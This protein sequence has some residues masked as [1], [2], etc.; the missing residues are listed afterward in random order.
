MK[1]LFL[2]TAN[3]CR[4]ILSEAVFNHL[5]PP[6]LR[7]FSAGSHARGEVLPRT[8]ATLRAAGIAVDGLTSK[9]IEAQ[10]DLNPDIVI[11]VCDQAAGDA[12]P[13]FLGKAIKV[14]W[15]LEDPSRLNGSEAEIIDAFDAALATIIRRTN[16]FLNLRADQLSTEQLQAELI[17]IGNL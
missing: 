9:A 12:C 7:A 6:G 14:H 1:V 13:L 10:A 4:S 3:S 15:G 16:A 17:R 2:C 8:L 11:T 5:A